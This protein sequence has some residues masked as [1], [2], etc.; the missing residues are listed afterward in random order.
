MTVLVVG[1]GVTG[2][3]AAAQIRAR[4][5]EVIVVDD[6]P[7]EAA[8]S[9]AAAAGIE[10]VVAP[11]EAGLR[12]LLRDCTTAVVSPGVPA[13]HPFYGAARDCGVEVV[14]EI[15]LAWRWTSTPIVAITGTNGKTTVTTLVAEMLDRA[16]TSALAA[17]NIGLPL[18][19]AV[20]QEADLYVAEVSSF[21]LE[22]TAGFRPSVATWLNLAEDH[23]DW[24]PSMAAYAAAKERVWANQG[25]G[26]VAIGN[27]DVDAVSATLAC[28]PSEVHITFGSSSAAHW[29]VRDGDIRMPGGEVFVRSQ[30]LP[31]SLPHDLENLAAA[32]ATA[33]AAGGSLDVCREVACSF[34]GLPHR[35]EL[36]AQ[37]GGVS[38][39]DDSKATT[40][41]SVLAAVRGFRSVVLL[42]GGRNKGLDLGVLREAADHI[43]AVVAFGEA[44][45][46]IE[47]TFRG[48]RPVESADSMYDAVRAAAGFAQDGDVVLLSPGCASY[49]WYR[50]YAERGEDF[51]RRVFE[52]VSP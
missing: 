21:Q 17:G 30:D 26:D 44:A 20:S 22:Y 25:Q 37:S 18:V 49:D 6:A 14:S 48:L 16:G 31:R 5:E 19:E 52:V 8:V 51:A 40:P 38:W 3:A 39:Y 46:E 29:Q 27:A 28:A 23:L 36:V 43:K 11:G 35:V 13:R 9:A 41:A 15:E 7:S 32:A 2:R 47:D 50:N 24:H 4:G 45:Q 42:A 1:F 10:L 33:L 12:A 34:Q